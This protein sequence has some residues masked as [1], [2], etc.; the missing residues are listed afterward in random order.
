MM[1]LDSDSGK[2]EDFKVSAPTTPKTK[3]ATTMT[4]TA[5]WYFIK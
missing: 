2:K 1:F 5:T 4:L 3:N